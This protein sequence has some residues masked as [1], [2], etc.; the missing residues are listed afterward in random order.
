MISCDELIGAH[1]TG[2]P[3]SG[4]AVALCEVGWVL[5]DGGPEEAA[6]GALDR[7]VRAARPMDG[8]PGWSGDPAQRADGGVVLALLHAASMLGLPAYEELAAEAGARV[9]GDP[10]DLD[11]AERL[12][13]G[14]VASGVPYR[15][16]PGLW[17]TACQCCGVAGL[18]E[19][20]AGL[21]AA[22]GRRA[23][24]RRCRTWTPWHGTGRCGG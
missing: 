13:A 16:V 22:T 21:W 4:I 7:V 12:A 6:V 1:H 18:V 2:G 3:L 11:W 8:G 24:A 15:R 23:S 17:D 20:F 10:G 5:G 19:L 14:I 9:A